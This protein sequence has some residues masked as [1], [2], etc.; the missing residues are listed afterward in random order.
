[1][2]ENQPE[3]EIRCLS[4]QETESLCNRLVSVVES[5]SPPAIP[6]RINHMSPVI[7]QSNLQEADEQGNRTI[8]SKEEKRV[9][10]SPLLFL[11]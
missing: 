2:Q 10:I 5:P 7:P 3:Q 4:Q 9:K 1:M 11:L 6:L 8:K